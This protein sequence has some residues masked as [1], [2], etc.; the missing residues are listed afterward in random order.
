M[1]EKETYRHSA[2]PQKEV[3]KG[4]PSRKDHGKGVK[5]GG[6]VRHPTQVRRV[7][8]RWREKRKEA[9]SKR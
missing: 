6:G 9:R 7:L 2:L 8:I 1:E 5:K 4:G 3:E